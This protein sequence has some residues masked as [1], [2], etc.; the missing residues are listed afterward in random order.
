MAERQTRLHQ[1]AM[2]LWNMV[3]GSYSTVI[4]S[5]SGKCGNIRIEPGF[6]GMMR[7]V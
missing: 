2:E 3:A 5:C 6:T 1:K 7:C 4:P